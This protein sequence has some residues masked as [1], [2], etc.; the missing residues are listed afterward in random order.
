M[1][2]RYRKRHIDSGDVMD[3]RD[4]NLNHAG[5]SDEFNG[6]LDRDNFPVDII[7]RDMMQSNCCNQ[8]FVDIDDETGRPLSSETVGWQSA[9]DGGIVFSRITAEIKADA[10][11]MC[12]WSGRWSWSYGD[13]GYSSW[14]TLPGSLLPRDPSN[15]LCRFRL[16]VDGVAVAESGFSSSRRNR[17]ACYLVGATPVV[18]GRHVIQIEGQALYEEGNGEVNDK[19]DLSKRAT[20][21]VGN[22]FELNL[23]D[24]ELIVRARYR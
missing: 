13:S 1:A 20:Y 24:R 8:F 5:Y 18:A 4:W 21:T 23:R 14:N 22:D 6:Y 12:E 9:T 16:T 2:F 17:D 3:P 10:L 19:F 11:L 7:T 15:A